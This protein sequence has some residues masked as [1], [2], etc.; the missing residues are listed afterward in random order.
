M[1][2][3]SPRDIARLLRGR[4]LI[5]M[6]DIDGT[7]CDIVERAGDARIP[8]AAQAALRTLGARSGAGTHLAFVTGRSVADARRM[9]HVD[10]AVIYG[11][12]GMERL[13][14][15]DPAD[16]PHLSSGVA[17]KPAPEL[18][19]AARE[20]R[21]CVAQF[22]GATLEDKG[23]SLSLH[24]R[25]M[26]PAQVPELSAR[27]GKI[28]RLHGLRMI[29]GKCVIN[30]LPADAWTKGDAVLDV[31]R[32]VEGVA[33]DA[34]ILFAGDDVTDEDAFRALDG[35][36]G[37]VTVRIGARDADSAARYVMPGPAQVHELLM[38]LADESA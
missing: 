37:A 22:P 27:V 10:G 29:D 7:L 35:L 5:I 26:D 6:L 30:V 19:A 31:I 14:S 21:S 3:A 24:Y 18:R 13:S 16:A 2:E 20:L 12:H 25:A 33:P 32:S 28:G 9:L 15:S 4:P 34:S 36:P 17:R 1:T 23:L 11:N 8:A 38:L